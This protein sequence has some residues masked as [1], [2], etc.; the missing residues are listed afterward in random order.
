MKGV[1]FDIQRFST[2]DGAGIRS[3]V[4]FKGC[5]LRC[6]WCENP[7]SQH[8]EP[9][10][11]FD[12]KRCIDCGACLRPEAGG[13]MHRDDSGRIA[14]RTHLAPGSV[15][16]AVPAELCPSL[17]IRVA[18]REASAQE[19]IDEVLKDEVFFRKS[20]GGVT[21]SGGEPLLQ[22]ALLE[23]LVAAFTGRG[24]DCAVES[25]LAVSPAALEK[26]PAYPITWLADLKHTDAAPFREGTG[27]DL[28]PVLA[29]LT[30]LAAG[31]AAVVLRVPVVPGF[32]DDEASL[33]RILEFAA[34]LP[35]PAPGKPR[36][37]LLPY[38]DLAAGKYAA[39]GRPY[40]YPHGLS[41][42]RPFLRRMAEAGRALGLDI[43]IG[44]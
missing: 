42:S 35:H 23:E 25:C 32:N 27:G 20:G 8:A 39:L 16:P 31:G 5:P 4:F 15:P 7:E 43:T 28:A 11:L 19:I 36:L 40:P 41:V 10:L 37:D 22:G 24:I 30:R 12:Q 29:N 38:H 14:A 9:E 33:R 13:F 44:G 21:F 17:A 6:A 1:F 2:H 26:L 3:I 18:G 34:A